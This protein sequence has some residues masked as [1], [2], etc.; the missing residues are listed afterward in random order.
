MRFTWR[1]EWPLWVLLAGMFLLAAITWS[2]A[3]ERIPV[4]WDMNGE[5]NGYGGKFEGLLLVPLIALGIYLIFLVM[6]R[7]DPLRANYDH[8]AGVYALFRFGVLAFLALV[9]GAIHLWIRG[10]RLPMRGLIPILTGGLLILIGHV[11]GEIR[12]NWFIGIRT[13]W[14]LSSTRSWTK[15][16]QVAGWVFTIEGASLILAGLF[17]SGG[18][19]VA[20]IAIGGAGIVGTIIYSYVVWRDDPDRVRPTGTLPPE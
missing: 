11:M 8:F 7:F 15:T 10:H 2:R 12:P 4:H 3:P 13:P 16:H 9:Y 19:L 5:V 1:T 18:A 6:P 20:S 17:H 14:T